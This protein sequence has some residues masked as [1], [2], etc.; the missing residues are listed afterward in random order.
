MRT[1]DVRPALTAVRPALTAARAAVAG[2]AA[3]ATLAW[4]I[5]N[6]DRQAVDRTPADVGLDFETWWWRTTRDR[7]GVTAWFVP[8]TGPHTVVVGH[9]M[10][11]SRAS[12]LEHVR[13]LHDA[14]HHVL[15]YDL[16]NHGSTDGSWRTWRMAARSMSDLRDA[17][18]AARRDP[19]VSGRLGVLAFSFSTWPAVHGL[20]PGSGVDAVVCDSGP[21]A[22]VSA[23]FRRLARIKAAGMPDWANDGIGLRTMVASCATTG[24]LLLAVRGWP[25]VHRTG[26]PLL[27][28]GGGRDRLLP[29]EEVAELARLL[30]ETRAWVAPRALHLHGLRSHPHEYAEV[31][32]GFFAG[33][34]GDH[35][36]RLGVAAAGGGEP[37]L[38]S[39]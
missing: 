6:P 22:D 25:P 9:G 17:I 2:T 7:L 11:R 24:R 19:R 39:G 32:L 23:G 15:A 33:A 38:N 14:G 31:V 27:L 35:E 28:I 37:C 36:S 26:P 4:K 8:S 5:Y 30:P 21:V 18:R 3:G 1:P 16:R 12:V 20:G 10:G 13:L 29:A 34:F